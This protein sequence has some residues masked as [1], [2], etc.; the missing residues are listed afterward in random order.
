MVQDIVLFAWSRV[1]LALSLLA[2]VLFIWVDMFRYQYP[3]FI[4]LL[5]IPYGFAGL[6]LAFALSTAVLSRH[7]I[8]AS[9]FVTGLIVLC[10]LV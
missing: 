4:T 1:A 7:W 10:D 8:H 6:G 5:T 9:L 3:D 2:V